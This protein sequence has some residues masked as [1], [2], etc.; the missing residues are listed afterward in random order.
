MDVTPWTNE[1]PRKPKTHYEREAL[2]TVPRETKVL[3]D[4]PRWKRLRH[5]FLVRH[6]LCVECG[7]VAREVDHVIEHYGREHLFW[8]W[9]NLQALCKSCHSKKTARKTI[10]VGR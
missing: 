7:S 3:Y 9:R 8:S 6:P 2:K 10:L 4:S 5:I 1:V